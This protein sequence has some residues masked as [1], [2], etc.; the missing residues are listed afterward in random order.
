[1]LAAGF[2]PV[3]LT[4]HGRLCG[5]IPQPVSTLSLSTLPSPVT[6]PFLDIDRDGD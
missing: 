1:M 2:K 4:L 5:S 6:L 3:G